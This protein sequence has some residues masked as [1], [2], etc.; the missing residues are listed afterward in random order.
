M[1]LPPCQSHMAAQGLVN[2]NLTE[3]PSDASP[4]PQQHK[5]AVTYKEQGFKNIFIRV[6]YKN[7]N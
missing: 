1:H 3:V 2:L 7:M 4:V 5:K 6:F